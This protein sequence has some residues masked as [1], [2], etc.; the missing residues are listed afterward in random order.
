MKDWI[1]D[2]LIKS[3]SAVGTI[4]VIIGFI[5]GVWKTQD[6]INDELQLKELKIEALKKEIQDLKDGVIWDIR[7]WIAN[8]SNYR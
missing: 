6:G 1:K 2:N 4:M 7:Q 3:F 8:P 5:A